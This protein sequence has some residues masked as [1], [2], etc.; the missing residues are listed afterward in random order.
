MERCIHGMDKAHCARCGAKPKLVVPTRTP[1]AKELP[2]EK[3]QD[4]VAPE[5]Q[6]LGYV[7]VRT[8]RGD[9]TLMHLGP[10]IRI[11][12]ID[13]DPNYWLL[14]EIVA[15]APNVAVI[16]VTPKRERNLGPRHRKLCQDAGVAIRTGYHRPDLAWQE[17]EIRS[18]Y[19][20]KNRSF[21]LGLSADQQRLFDEL[22]LMGLEAA[23]ITSRYFCLDDEPY[24][25][26]HA[27]GQE[28]GI[29]SESHVS[30]K[31]YTVLRYLDPGFDTIPAVIVSVEALRRKVERLRPY[32]HD[33]AKRQ[34]Y[35]ERLGLRSL[36]DRLPV[37]WFDTFEQ[38]VALRRN[39][40]FRTLE[41][42][43]P[44]LATVLELRFGLTKP[45]SHDAT[46]LK[47]Q[48]IGERLELTR[49]RVR[50]LIEEALTFLHIET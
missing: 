26:L 15:R 22:M 21:L 39:G 40:K 24:L 5:M 50:Q 4:S 47:L 13:G 9:P 10:T 45:G 16:Q 14:E 44:R 43:R 11:V 49:E 2:A 6:A 25:T 42:M 41:V 17:G 3:V 35:A 32:V 31:T 38:L 7:V 1:I 27:V 34:A 18:P 36:P 20:Q 37:A 33:A 19:F 8:K 28:F 48:E 12:H 46:C 29:A 30:V 23:Q